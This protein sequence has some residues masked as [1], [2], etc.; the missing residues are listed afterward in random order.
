[1]VQVAIMIGAFR[2]SRNFLVDGISPSVRIFRLS[3]VMPHPVA[4]SRLKTGIR[5]I[6]RMDGN[7]EDTHFA[8]L[9]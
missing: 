1:M 6:S 3:L 5:T 8:G 4:L 2:V 9:A 7:A